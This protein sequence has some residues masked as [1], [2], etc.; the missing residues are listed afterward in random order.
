MLRRGS[1]LVAL[2]LAACGG[3][4]SQ[5]GLAGSGPV[6][7][8][9]KRCGA[10][11]GARVAPVGSDGT[12]STVALVSWN[13][14]RLAIVADEDE[15]AV[16]TL[17]LASRRRLASTPVGGRPAQLLVLADG[18]VL[19]ANRDRSQLMLL[20]PGSDPSQP[21]TVD[22]GVATPTEPVA[23]ATTPDGATVIVSSGWGHALSGYRV[24][25]LARTFRVDL[26]REPRA[27]VVA[28]DGALAYVSHA[29]GGKISMVALGADHRVVEL[30][31]GSGA[32]PRIEQIRQQVR[33]ASGV[34]AA[35][36]LA[37]LDQ[38]PDGRRTSCQGYALAKSVDPV[39]R[40]LA[41]QVLVDPGDAQ[42]RPTGYGDDN[43]ATE[44]QSVAV[45]DARLGTPLAASLSLPQPSWASPPGEGS[46]EQCLL[47]RA[48]VVDPATRTLL[49]AC[50]G[51]DA[52]IAYDA[53][54]ATPS[55]TEKR[56]WNVASGPTGIAVDPGRREAVVWSQFDRSLDVIPLAHVEP[57]VDDEDVPA[58]VAH[59]ALPSDP[60]RRLDVAARLGRQLFFATGDARISRDGRAC[61]SCHPDGRDDGLVWATPNG[62]RRSILLAG[63]L[64]DTAPYSWEGNE[65]D[66][67]RHLVKTFDRLHG[68]GGLRSVELD[69]LLT[70][71]RSL[72][73]PPR[74]VTPDDV[75]LRRGA[76]LFVSAEVG[77]S[78]CHSGPA[79]T[80]GA[81]HDIDSHAE[82]DRERKF[83]TP[84]LRFVGAKGPW[85]HDGRYKTLRELLVKEDG[86]MGHTHGLSP[87]DL[88]A[89][90]A[91]VRS[92]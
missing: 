4:R 60:A 33:A 89:L 30:G 12:G 51:I 5:A 27:V 10:R 42:R 1:I 54:A 63:R 17:D 43:A 81:L 52:V 7:S 6:A 29:V 86:K 53:S 11:P 15:H 49:V 24:A 46:V 3:A 71:V 39:G 25:D 47:P 59:F 37:A 23:L 83:N 61:A 19:V 35:A 70:Y 82:V 8:V 68:A 73:P 31:V 58:E 67:R 22:C 76:Q 91:Y 55:Q 21:L 92:L 28:D 16:H 56:R 87:A 9:A 48:A 80:D 41:P 26:P 79:F 18:R 84:S 88:D 20:V 69:A 44:L 85:F 57:S 13:G 62:P 65:A 34:A 36:Q 2:S 64:A 77:C 90:E 75:E 78:H 50:L 32:D 45:I 72:P 66:L 38:L 74:A 14:R 40:I